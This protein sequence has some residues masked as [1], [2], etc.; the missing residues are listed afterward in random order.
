[1]T[2]PL[3]GPASRG[4]RRAAF[5]VVERRALLA[6]V[7]AAAACLLAACFGGDPAP[8][9]K[10]EPTAL[11]AADLHPAKQL[12]DGGTLRLG[13]ESFPATFNPVHIDGADSTAPQILAPT[14]GSA[15]RVA[16]DGSWQVDPDYATSVEVT[17]TDPLTV[18]V[19]L[20]RRAVWQGGTPI[21]SADMVAY[22]AAM[23][24]DE[25]ASAAAP[26]FD[27][28][29]QVEPDGKFAYDVVFAR[30][31]ADWPAAVYPGLPAAVTRDAT[32]FNTGLVRQAPS[33]NGP[34]R[35]ASIEPETGTITL[36][37]NPRW[38][39][40]PP[41]LDSIVWRI[42]TADVLAKAYRAGELDAAP[43]TPETRTDFADSADLR[44]A[45]G[46]E[47]SHLTINGGTGPLAD[48]EVRRAVMLA[49]D[50]DAIVQATG[51]RFGVPATAMD[52]VVYLPGQVGHRSQLRPRDL[53]AAQQALTR[54]GWVRTDETGPVQ[55]DGQAL[56]LRLPVPDTMTGAV[57]RAKLIAADLAEVGIEVTVT[58]V[59]GDTF[60]DQVVIPLD[61]DLTT[62]TW[63]TGPFPVTSARRLFTPIDSPLNFTGKASGAIAAAFDDAIGTLDP[64]AREE[65]VATVDEVARAQASILPLAV[66][67]EVM[68]VRSSVANYGPASLA[69]LDWTTVGF[70]AKKS[71]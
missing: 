59:P 9:P 52:S 63:Q 23:R 7:L 41:K 67:P 58:E 16:E 12:R 49:V 46:S 44:A 10:A 15:V 64:A 32:V 55:R 51:T 21:T 39:G 42:G 37:R 60:F 68:V 13:I 19:E 18:R 47:W 5:P 57:Q 4:A 2:P 43:V 69:D 25:F 11:P 24:S 34:Y 56:N 14:R 20:N 48:A 1:M 45:Q 30:P 40:R 54:A 61:F 36:E 6:L 22:V 33:A 35:V 65:R 62:F 50:T 3:P 38:W 27:D 26:V 66:I 29:R 53:A 71:S 70:R 31:D 8:K 28:V 17:G